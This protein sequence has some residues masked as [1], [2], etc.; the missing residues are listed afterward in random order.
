MRSVLWFFSCILLLIAPA[1]SRAEEQKWI[2]LF[3][4]KTLE[5]WLAAD[6]AGRADAS[7]NQSTGF[8]KYEE[9]RWYRVHIKVTDKKLE[10]WVD[11]ELMA[12]VELEG[13]KIEMRTGEIEASQPLGIA[14]YR[15]K[16]AL[17][18]IRWRPV[19]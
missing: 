4:G 6:V 2:S 19:K 15:T 14:S 18:D 5:S 1:D 10:A 16:S 11:E 8:K 17:K 9:G 13:L 7:E 3:D 12:D